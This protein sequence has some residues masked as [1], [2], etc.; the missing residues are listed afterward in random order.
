MQRSALFSLAV[1]AAFVFGLLAL[2]VGPSAAQPSRSAAAGPSTDAEPLVRQRVRPRTKLRVRP[3]Y[4]YRRSHA[5]YPL[6]YDTE[7]PGPNA[8][9]ECVDRYVTEYRPSGAVIVPRMRCWWV[10]G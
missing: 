8:K 3:L 9:R 5:L 1:F 4:P 10:R 2:G 6:P 7:F